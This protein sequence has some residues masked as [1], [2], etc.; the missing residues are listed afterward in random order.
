MIFFNN[1]E[2]IF[3]DS[4]ISITFVISLIKARNSLFVDKLNFYSFWNQIMAVAGLY[5]LEINSKRTH[6]EGQSF[7]GQITLQIFQPKH[8]SVKYLQFRSQQ[9]RWLSFQ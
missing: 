3:I 1:L 2:N 9:V 6:V 4:L 7:Y 5:W 8:I